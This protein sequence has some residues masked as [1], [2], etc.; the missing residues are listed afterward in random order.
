MDLLVRFG[1]SDS[2]VSLMS[3]EFDFDEG[4][5]GAEDA[6]QAWQDLVSGGPLTS[7]DGRKSSR[8]IDADTAEINTDL[9]NVAVEAE[10]TSLNMSNGVDAA[11]GTKDGPTL[12][13]AE[14]L[15]DKDS[16]VDYPSSADTEFLQNAKKH[17]GASD[18]LLE[19]LAMD[20]PSEI[21]EA[22]P[23]D[24]HDAAG[25]IDMVCGAEL[26]H[27]FEAALERGSPVMA[28]LGQFFYHGEGGASVITWPRLQRY[29]EDDRV[30]AYFGALE[31]EPRDI[32]KLFES[33]RDPSLPIDS[34]LQAA[35]RLKLE[36]EWEMKRRHKMPQGQQR[37]SAGQPESEALFGGSAKPLSDV[38]RKPS[39]DSRGP[40]QLQPPRVT[41]RRRPSGI[42]SAVSLPVLAQGVLPTEETC[43][44]ACSVAAAASPPTANATTA[45]SGDSNGLAEFTGDQ[46]RI[47]T[48]SASARLVENE[49][50]QSA[51]EKEAWASLLALGGERAAEQLARV[52]AHAALVSQNLP[53]LR[54]NS[55]VTGAHSDGYSCSP[56]RIFPTGFTAT[57]NPFRV[58]ARGCWMWAR[59]GYCDAGPGCPYDHP[60]LGRVARIAAAASSARAVRSGPYRTSRET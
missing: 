53:N 42:T 4:T 5:A 33:S 7:G 17:G 50:A 10:S 19:L 28:R 2:L 25:P 51:E 49:D 24:S 23:E 46:T 43:G 18:A 20:D 32:Q 26:E 6:A 14:K 15:S 58:G 12:S 1:A 55:Q 59:N 27:V 36:A 21:M 47:G 30:L 8:D 16:F 54:S 13:A 37:G 38:A 29:L 48:T 57:G 56:E 22:G 44:S 45:P 34:F 41:L 11:H 60:V 35:L 52:Q 31:L 40:G 9:A 3:Q 39:V